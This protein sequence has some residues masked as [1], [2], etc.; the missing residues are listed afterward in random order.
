MCR[1]RRSR[2]WFLAALGAWL[3]LAASTPAGAA[4]LMATV[5]NETRPTR[6]A[7]EDNVS[8]PVHGAGIRRFR[9]EALQPD[10]LPGVERDVTAPDFSACDFDGSDH[11]TDPKHAFVPRSR[12]LHDGARWRI[13]GMTLPV[14]WRPDRVPVSIDG[15]ADS[16]FHL[17]QL[18]RKT[19]G[20]GLSEVLVMY[21]ADGYWR[22]KPLP[23]ARFGDG[24]YGSSMLFGPVEQ[25]GRPIVKIASIRVATRPMAVHLT[26]ADGSRMVA[27]V[28]ETSRRRTVLDVR[29]SR[30]SEADRP[31]AVLRS[32]YVSDDNADVSELRSQADP[33]AP[34]RTTPLP[35]LDIVAGRAFRFGRSVVSR[36]NTSA[37]DLL[38]H[39]F[40]NGVRP[41]AHAARHAG[42]ALTA[43]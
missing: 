28:G 31:F 3:A 24:V 15:R 36:H 26:L 25:A 33:K 20:G 17:I 4:P 43:Y 21:P 12:V 23:E 9:I 18:F 32:M 37:P 14:F 29:T 19:P 8:L 39:G 2:A 10:Y 1:P 40:G 7:E 6:C 13:V 27:R 35:E 41:P 38:L 30:A 22:L 5:R 42:R 34:W 16:G 11:P